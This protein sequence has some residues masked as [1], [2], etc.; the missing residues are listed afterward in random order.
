MEPKATD[1]Q[2][3]LVHAQD[4]NRGCKGLESLEYP[5]RRLPIGRV[6]GGITARVRTAGG[7]EPSASPIWPATAR[8]V[9][10]V[11]HHPLDFRCLPPGRP[12]HKVRS[13]TTL[14]LYE[15]SFQVEMS[16]SL[17]KAGKCPT[18][19]LSGAPVPLDK[20]PCNATDP[21]PGQ[22]W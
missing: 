16:D 12:C 17:G 10:G 4:L 19:R 21:P 20:L 3:F 14:R 8:L 1:V 13:A 5:V 11:S 7:H 9:R 2:G 18:V 22:T 6:I 15:N